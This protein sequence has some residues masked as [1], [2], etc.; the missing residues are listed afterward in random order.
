MGPIRGKRTALVFCAIGL[1]VA[2]AFAY[3][4]RDWFVEVYWALRAR[5]DDPVVRE[6]ALEALVEL[7]SPRAVAV[8]VDSLCAD[9]DCHVALEA[10]WVLSWFWDM[11]LDGHLGRTQ[12]CLGRLRAGRDVGPKAVEPLREILG[13]GDPLRS[14]V[15][16]GLLALLGPRASEAAPDLE[17]LL[18][19]DDPKVRG[20][21]GSALAAVGCFH[22]QVRARLLARMEAKDLPLA[23]RGLAA[24]VLAQVA[25]AAVYWHRA[26]AGLE[27][28]MAF[29]EDV[30]AVLGRTEP[31]AARMALSV[32]TEVLPRLRTV[33]LSGELEL[34]S[35][36]LEVSHVLSLV[37]GRDLGA[38]HPDDTELAGALLEAL[39]ASPD[40]ALPDPGAASVAKELK[41]LADLAE[42]LGRWAVPI[43]AK[44]ARA[45]ELATRERAARVLLELSVRLGPEGL[46]P[47]ALE[48]EKLV[49]T[50]LEDLEKLEEPAKLEVAMEEVVVNCLFALQHTL[51]NPQEVLDAV[52]PAL[53][54]RAPGVRAAAADA[55]RDLANADLTRRIREGPLE[56]GPVQGWKGLNRLLEDPDSV[57]RLRA[58]GAVARIACHFPKPSE[59]ILPLL[60]SGDPDVR[61]GSASACGECPDLGE[62]VDAALL[63]AMDDPD[64]RVKAEAALSLAGLSGPLAERYLAKLVDLLADG[65]SEAVRRAALQALDTSCAGV[66]DKGCGYL[67]GLLSSEDRDVREKALRALS[68]VADGKAEK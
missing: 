17:R 59:T 21:A 37:T 60:R 64:P 6:R 61:L 42:E 16:A 29:E 14:R 40:P 57:V 43:L 33:E 49:Q 54:S 38:V 62:E 65:P 28:D 26:C 20:A 63:Q 35:D 24:E 47:A 34:V 41:P 55:W 51:S 30:E 7:R 11:G 27:E 3:V 25:C 52:R 36:G 66:T 15:A 2:A 67:Q 8:A 5:S 9:E 23:A 18:D 19:A 45:G 39:L 1:L 13:G 58:A 56:S 68:A 31:E 50:L 48:V 46:G 22:P 32:A 44:A 12:Q 10:P 53:S 4:E